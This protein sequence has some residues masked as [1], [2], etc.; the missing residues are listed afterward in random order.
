MGNWS[1]FDWS[2]IFKSN[3]LNIKSQIGL[4][5]ES[6]IGLNIE[7]Q[8]GSTVRVKLSTDIVLAYTRYIVLIVYILY[9]VATCVYKI[10]LI[11]KIYYSRLVFF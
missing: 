9:I 10:Q 6:Q 8:I 5:I 7:S 2:Q 11:N 3:C 1:Q 4:N